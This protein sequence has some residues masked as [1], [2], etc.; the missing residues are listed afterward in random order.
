V[1]DAEATMKKIEASRAERVAQ[2]S[3]PDED[4]NADAFAIR[5][6]GGKPGQEVEEIHDAEV[7]VVSAPVDSRGRPISNPTQFLYHKRRV[8][9]DVEA[10]RKKHHTV[11]AVARGRCPGALQG[12]RRRERVRL[13]GSYRTRSTGT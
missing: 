5:S 7:M 10:K 2:G 12:A 6:G 9:V 13:R 8:I 3:P 11:C 1:L 4:R